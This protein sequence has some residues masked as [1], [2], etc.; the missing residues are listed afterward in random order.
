MAGR[1]YRIDQS[2]THTLLKGV[3]AL[4][5]ADMTSISRPSGEVTGRCAENT[6][7]GGG[8]SGVATVASGFHWF[9]GKTSQGDPGCH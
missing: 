5:H 4:R 1:R 2:V 6:L 3:P 8:C 9:Y 7:F